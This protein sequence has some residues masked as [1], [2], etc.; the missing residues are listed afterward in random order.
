LIC[1]NLISFNLSYGQN[2]SSKSTFYSSF[3]ELFNENSFD[4]LH[5]YPSKYFDFINPE[6]G[7]YIKMKG[8]SIRIKLIKLLGIDTLTGST[9]ITAIEKFNMDES[10]SFIGYII[11]I[12]EDLVIP[13]KGL[14]IF[15]DAVA[16]WKGQ[17]MQRWKEKLIAAAPEFDFPIHR[18]FIELTQEEKNLLWTGNKQFR[19]LNTFF[20]YIER[21]SYKIQYRVML[22][23]YRG[24]TMCPECKG[25]RLRADADYVKI[26]GKS[27]L[28]LVLLPVSKLLEFFKDLKLD[29]HDKVVGKRLLLEI[30]SRLTVLCEVGL[31]YLTLNRLSNTLS[32]GESQRINLSTSI[33]SS[34]VGAMYILDE[35]SIGLHPRDTDRL[36]SVLKSLKD[37]GNTVIVV[38]HDE[39]I[40]K[41][42][43]EIVDLG[44]E[45]GM[46]GGELVFHGDHK[47]LLKE[48]VSLTARYLN[49]EMA[50]EVPKKRK[51]WKKFIEVKGA[52]ENN[53]KGI[54]VKFPLG[55]A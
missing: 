13:D 53:L 4:T 30:T 17:K 16:C 32:G 48:K 29:D 46:D 52:R 51:P 20:K 31:E 21:K 7:K 49:G 19:G 43:D 27:I 47:S 5:V 25:T 24:K 2:K 50:I 1:F 36:I 6:N 44:P 18:P 40:M 38:E 8:I 39:E 35:P 28:E 15:E 22:S 26:G 3:S 11:G 42:S 14:S 37:L 23:R 10:G 54:D 9:N 12:D 34:L 41:A 55:G 45:A 33:G